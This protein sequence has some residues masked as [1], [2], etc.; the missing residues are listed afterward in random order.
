MISKILTFLT[1]LFFVMDLS[2]Q[3]ITILSAYTNEPL[4][5][6]T[7]QNLRAQWAQV[8]S[9]AGKF[10]FND[11]NCKKGDSILITYTGYN[12]VHLVKP[13]MDVTLLMKPLPATLQP[14]EVLPCR[15]NKTNKLVN[16]K[17]NQSGWSLASNEKAL[18]SWAAYIPNQSK[19][20]A[21]ISSIRFSLSMTWTPKSARGA[22]YKIKLLNYD[23]ANQTPG[24]PLVFK[25][26][27]VYPKSKQVTLDLKD[28]KLRL[29]ANGLVVAIDFFYAG[30]Q[31][32]HTHKV[33]QM[34]LDST[35]KDTLH[36]NYGS[37]IKAVYADNVIGNGYRY[38]YKKN[39]WYALKNHKNEPM[40]PKIEIAIKLCE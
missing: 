38:S 6:A 26:F 17:K 5:F 14:V 28:E 27:V 18:A 33:M 34:Q 20:K 15:G 1:F 3:T 40:A 19:A 39:S 9:E 29:P 25:E 13:E 8:G 37:S 12:S 31:F 2:A 4:P 32:I 35:Y 11:I 23:A 24:T 22:P 16:F 30:E 10:T 7:I 21:T 36:S